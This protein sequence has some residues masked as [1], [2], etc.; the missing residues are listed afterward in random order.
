M[1]G[2]PP[3]GGVL[4]W[5]NTA[6]GRTRNT[7][8]TKSRTILRENMVRISSLF[9][10]ERNGINLVH[11]FHQL[12]GLLECIP[13]DVEKLRRPDRDQAG[14]FR[15]GRGNLADKVEFVVLH[16]RRD[17][18]GRLWFRGGGNRW[19]KLSRYFVI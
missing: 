10:F 11:E 3:G 2:R 18:H 15:A 14:G 7:N 9:H 17:D 5:A 19:R 12:C 1:V 13:L 16:F 8:R 4:S 6:K